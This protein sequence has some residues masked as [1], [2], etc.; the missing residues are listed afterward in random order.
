MV[1]AWEQR[2][3]AQTTQTA[4]R[5][6]RVGAIASKDKSVASS[7]DRSIP[8]ISAASQNIRSE[9]FESRTDTSQ[10]TAPAPSGLRPSESAESTPPRRDASRPASARE[11]QSRGSELSR[12]STRTRLTEAPALL[13][14]ARRSSV[15]IVP[16]GVALSDLLER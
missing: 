3:Q 6:G 15:R 4:T 2:V 9:Y 7:V 13:L 12:Q 5:S 8:R 10:G 1:L 16:H 11:T 14:S